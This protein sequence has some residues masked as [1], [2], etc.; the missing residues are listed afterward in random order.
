VLNELSKRILAGEIDNKKPI[1]VDLENSN[2][3]FKN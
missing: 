1:I 3:V 2:L